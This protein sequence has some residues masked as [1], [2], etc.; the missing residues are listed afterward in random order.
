MGLAS[1][2]L[3]LGA[4]VLL[5][6]AV[7]GQASERR[8]AFEVA[9]QA[10]MPAA[11]REPLVADAIREDLATR[12]GVDIDDIDLESYESVTWP[13]GCLGVH[14]PGTVCAQALT[15]GF[16]AR[17]S[18]G[19]EIFRYHGSGTAFVAVNFLPG[20]RVAGPV[21]GADPIRSPIRSIS[22]DGQALVPGSRGFAP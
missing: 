4:I 18:H 13:D 15:P 20:A 9:A 22:I 1:P 21:P 10:G 7:F 17:A 11:F 6:L 12:L 16:L 8:D 14:V 2:W 5:L 19:D 3:D